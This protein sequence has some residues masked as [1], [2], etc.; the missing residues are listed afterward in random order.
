M[1]D[2]FIGLMSGTSID[3]IDAV[4]LEVSNQEFKLVSSV[5]HPIPQATKSDIMALCSPGDNEIQRMGQLDNELAQ[6]FATATKA[7]LQKADIGGDQIN[8]IGSH[9]QTIRHMPNIPNGFTLQIGNPALLTELTGI[10]TVAD[11]RRADI[12]AGGQGAPLVPA[13]HQAAFS[14]PDKNRVIVNIG[15]MA[16]ISILENGEVSGFDTGPGNVLMNAWVHRHLNKSYDNNGEWAKAHKVD[17]LLLLQMLTDPYFHQAPPKS[18]GRE[19]FN[20][21]WLDKKIKKIN[22]SIEPGNVQ[23]SLV[24]LTATSISDAIKQ[25]SSC[26][27]VYVCGGGAHNT[28]LMQ[29]LE[30]NLQLPVK[31]THELGIDPSFV[32]AAAF[33]WFA[34]RALA[35]IPS[36]E[37]NVTGAQHTVVMGAIYP[38]CDSGTYSRTGEPL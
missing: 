27:E 26:E 24:Q 3:A 20:E 34:Q 9:G 23:A 19:L 5:E 31:T 32:E 11:F 28:Y 15:G 25:Y 16:N 36:N 18:T 10:T 4:L 17:E 37:P 29:L 30:Q 38:R 33:A 8:A 1:P 12:A 7:L 14:H 35:A 2:Y 6:L 22:Q 13:F 21:S